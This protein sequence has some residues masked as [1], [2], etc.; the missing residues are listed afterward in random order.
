MVAADFDKTGLSRLSL[1]LFCDVKVISAEVYARDPHEVVS[2]TLCPHLY[3][4]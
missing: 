3:E 4:S 2:V 1:S